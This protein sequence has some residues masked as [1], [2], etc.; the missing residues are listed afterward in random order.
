MMQLSNYEIIM[1]LDDSRYLLVNGL[2][3]AF[4]VVDLAEGKALADG[5]FELIA[6]EERKRLL[7]R[8]HLTE[9]PTD[10]I[11]D[12]KFMAGFYRN[13][14]AESNLDLLIL[15][16]YDCNFRC[17]YCFERHRLSRGHEWLCR[18]MSHEMVDAIFKAVEK[19]KQRGVKARSCM[20]Y[21]GEPFLKKNKELVRYI[22]QKAS[23]AEMTLSAVTNG[24]DL[25]HYTDLLEEYHFE[26]IQISLDGIK[27]DN[28]RRRVYSGGG[29]SFEKILENT[30]LAASKGIK[31]DLRINT[32]SSNLGQV[33][34]LKKVFE[35][36]GLTKYPKFE[37]YFAPTIGESGNDT[38]SGL[39]YQDIVEALIQNG[40][41]KK[42]ALKHTWHYSSYMNEIRQLIDEQEYFR[43]SDSHCGA[44]KMMYLIDPEGDIYTCWYFVAMEHMRVGRVDMEKEKFAWNFSLLQWYFR[45]V[46]KM[47]ECMKCPYVFIC[48]GGCASCSYSETG[49]ISD[50]Y[51]GEIKEIFCDSAIEVC[52][53]MFYTKKERELTK[54][55]K[56][57]VLTYPYEGKKRRQ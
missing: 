26:S 44:E 7:A 39:R 57:L 35:D 47:P 16:T 42:D 46:L 56:N 53:E 21:G 1:P 3:Y 12:L 15:P 54:S 49:N 23:D 45:N 11:E 34:L 9:S 24:Y 32:G 29:G 33:H 28:D 50:P 5:K 14:Y 19:E 31:V 20:L 2:Y 40:F 17:P 6:D 18:T 37:Y 10:E 52:R 48:R 41:E 43:P 8:G 4:D 36:R 55:L 30:E 13:Y 27:E 51:C 25:D 22:V 38:N